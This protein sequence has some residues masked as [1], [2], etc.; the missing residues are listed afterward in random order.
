[1]ERGSEAEQADADSG[2]EDNG[3]FGSGFT[4]L[5]NTNALVSEALIEEPVASGGDSSLWT[6]GEDDGEKDCPADDPTCK[7]R[8]P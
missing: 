7:D 4:G 2:S 3:G 6:D 5:V 1:V 8:E